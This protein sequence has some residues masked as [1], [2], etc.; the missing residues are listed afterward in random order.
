MLTLTASSVTKG[1]LVKDADAI[2]LWKKD[3]Q[4]QKDAGTPSGCGRRAN[5]R[6]MPMRS[7]SG[8]RAKSWPS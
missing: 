7:G 4:L 8:R 5:S 2:W 6:R 3:Q 1:E